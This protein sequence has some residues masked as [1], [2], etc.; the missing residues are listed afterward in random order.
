MPE[1]QQDHDVKYSK[2]TEIQY[3]T[4]IHNDVSMLASL[5]RHQVKNFYHHL[6][7]ISL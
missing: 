5:M 3:S 4:I 2:T 1:Q 6:V 7:Y